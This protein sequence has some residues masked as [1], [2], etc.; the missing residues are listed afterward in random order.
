MTF[1]QPSCHGCVYYCISFKLISHSLLSCPNSLSTKPY[2]SSLLLLVVCFTRLLQRCYNCS[3]F[4]HLSPS[5]LLGLFMKICC[6]TQVHTFVSKRVSSHSIFEII[7]KFIFCFFDYCKWS[8]Y[9]ECCCL[10]SSFSIA[11]ST[12]NI[13]SKFCLYFCKNELCMQT[14]SI[15]FWIWWL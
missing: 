2:S 15:T 13:L 5:L 12:T 1:I 10:V 9:N 8:S 7:V 3:P 4:L 14:W 6:P 11:H